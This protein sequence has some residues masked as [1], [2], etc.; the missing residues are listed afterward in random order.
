[1]NPA[2]SFKL[3]LSLFRP[4]PSLCHLHDMSLVGTREIGM[5]GN[6]LFC[7]EVGLFLLC[8]LFWLQ[9]SGYLPIRS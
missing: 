9:G 1:M 7:E 6:E 4:V 8:L 2:Y 5:G 3:V